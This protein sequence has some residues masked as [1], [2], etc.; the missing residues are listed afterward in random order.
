MRFLD[1][2]RLV[3]AIACALAGVSLAFMGLLAKDKLF[4]PPPP[5]SLPQT[6]KKPSMS[7]DAARTPSPKDAPAK[8]DAPGH[9]ASTGAAPNPGQSGPV[10]GNL[11]VITGL[12][13]QLEE[14]RLRAAI[15]QEAEKI[16][17]KAPPQV[18]AQPVVAIPEA[19][20][21][22]AAGKPKPVILSIQ[23]MDGRPTATV[24]HGSEVVSLRAGDRFNGGVVASIDRTGV[25]IRRGHSTTS[26]PFELEDTWK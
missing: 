10:A 14:V 2:K 16:Q 20:K 1:K 17:P 22:Q 9:A 24:R 25:S 6:A 7:K 8:T 26:L 5:P 19:S 3:W 13:A 23:G 12:R 11:G 15:A 21:P 18:Q 4:Q